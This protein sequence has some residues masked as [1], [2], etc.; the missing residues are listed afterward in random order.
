MMKGK[1]R[2]LPEGWR[3]EKLSNVCESI[4]Y[5]YTT[6][7]TKAQVG[8]KLLRITDIQSGEICW[9]DVP[10]CDCSESDKQKYKVTDGDIVF[11]RTGSTG[12]SCLIKNPPESVFASFLI[13][14]IRIKLNAEFALPNYVIQYFKSP[15]YWSVINK[16]MRGGIQKGFNATMLSSF[17]IPLPPTLDDQIRIAN[18]LERKMAEVE[19][20][21]QAAHR[22]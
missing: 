18:E 22:Q 6:S 5:G 19:K 16:Q 9:N 11:A 2:K 8:P 4:E 7:A 21:R 13:R 17:E 3:W 14:I 1:K 15:F 10:Y 20:I 12:N